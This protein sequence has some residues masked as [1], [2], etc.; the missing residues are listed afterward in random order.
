LEEAISLYEWNVAVSAALF[1]RLHDVEIVIRNAMHRQLKARH[2]G[3]QR[4]GS[5]FDDPYR[6]LTER[7]RKD[8]TEAKKRLTSLNRPLEEGRLVAELN[9]SF[10]AFLLSKRYKDNLWP[11]ALRFAFPRWKGAPS[12]LFDALQRLR[13][14][15]NRVAHHEPIIHRKLHLDERDCDR[16]LGAICSATREW[17]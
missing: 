13:D 12:A 8:V 11:W 14:L 10:W 16:V 9:F 1:E 7:A 17:S 15:R 2:D 3:L 6:E 5:W 4:P